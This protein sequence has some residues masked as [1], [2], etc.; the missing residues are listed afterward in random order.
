MAPEKTSPQLIDK[1]SR[2]IVAIYKD[3]G[4]VAKLRSFNV[5]AVGAA[6]AQAAKFIADETVLWSQVVRDAKINPTD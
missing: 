6:P 1:I 2:E 5:D 3:A 4:F